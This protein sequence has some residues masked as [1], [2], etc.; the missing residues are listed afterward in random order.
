MS[1]LQ[2]TTIPSPVST[3]PF[4]SHKFHFLSSE[5]G[6]FRTSFNKGNRYENEQPSYNLNANSQPHQ[7]W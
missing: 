3:S 1:M 7:E 5:M 6:L 4:S 2:A